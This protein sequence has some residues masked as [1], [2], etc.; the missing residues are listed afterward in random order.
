MGAAAACTDFKCFF[1][2]AAVQT[3]A[4]DV[5]RTIVWRAAEVKN[6]HAT[7]R[8]WMEVR[9]KKIYASN[10][11]HQCIPECCVRLIGLMKFNTSRLEFDRARALDVGSRTYG[12]VQ[13][14]VLKAPKR[15]NQFKI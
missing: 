9:E 15:A 14:S 11:I 2:V 8:Q 3:G 10:G 5:A 12:M 6:V 4:D 1:R 13:D 7:G